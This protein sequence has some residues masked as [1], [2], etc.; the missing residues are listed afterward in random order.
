LKS[1]GYKLEDGWWV[2]NGQR[3]WTDKYVGQHHSKVAI[4][5]GKQSTLDFVKGVMYHDEHA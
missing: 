1:L 4:E 2:K 3:V 5:A